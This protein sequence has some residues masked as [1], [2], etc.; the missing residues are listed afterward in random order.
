MSAIRLSDQVTPGVELSPKRRFLS[1]LFGGRLD[2]PSACTPTSVATVELMDETGAAFPDAHLDPRL[3]A[4]LAL[5]GHE[6]LGFDTV[7]P[8]FS[9]ITEAAALGAEIDWGK[10]DWLP[11]NTTSPWTEPEDIH[12]PDDFLDRPSTRTALEAISLIQ[13]EA[14]DRVGIIGKAMGPWTLAYHM[15][16]V[17]AFLIN[18]AIDH[19]KARRILEGLAPITV[20]FARAQMRTGADAICIADHST[21]DM[22]RAETYRDFLLPI[23]QRINRELGAPTIFHCCGKSLDRMD[24]YSQ[25]GFD[26]Y[27]FESANDAR[28][29]VERV[30]GRISLAGNINGP[31]TLLSGSE[32]D[33]RAET[34]YAARAGV[35]LIGPECAIALTTP[36]RNLKA[37]TSELSAIGSEARNERL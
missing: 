36:N 33:A 32:D 29:A 27:H 37:I 17:E 15:F 11:I 23:H 8:L 16:G 20:M 10:R 4:R 24:Y 3:M 34:R 6:I 1:A 30:G 19:D 12:T 26:A 31:K 28:L 35:T 7:A 21:G 13:K 5:G 2:R 22:V 9:V 25:A 14:G 18:I